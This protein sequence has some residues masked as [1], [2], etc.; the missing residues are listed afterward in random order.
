MDRLAPLFISVEM[1]GDIHREHPKQ[2]S[3]GD[4][5]RRSEF[6]RAA[7]EPCDIINDHKRNDDTGHVNPEGAFF[8]EFTLKRKYFGR[9]E[10]DEKLFSLQG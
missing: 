10:A 1:H 6:C 5:F 9:F 7:R 4:Q 3:D 2:K 8:H